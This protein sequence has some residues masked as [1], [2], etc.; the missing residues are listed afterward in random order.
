MR[1]QVESPCDRRDHRLEAYATFF[2]RFDSYEHHS[3]GFATKDVVVAVDE[4]NV[5]LADV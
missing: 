2:T 5:R 3:K 1:F 4:P